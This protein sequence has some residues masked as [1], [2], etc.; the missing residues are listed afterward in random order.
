[1]NVVSQVTVKN[2]IVKR[3]G[4]QKQIGHLSKIRYY[5]IRGIR[6][7]YA[8]PNPLPTGYQEVNKIKFQEQVYFKIF[9]IFRFEI[10]LNFEVTKYNLSTFID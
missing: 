10:V 4:R 7:Y 2:E 1:M 8:R 5:L 9:I 6:N 3:F